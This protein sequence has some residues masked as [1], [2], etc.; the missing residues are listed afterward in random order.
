[1]K[2]PRRVGGRDNTDKTTHKPRRRKRQSGRKAGVQGKGHTA[3]GRL[4]EVEG[5]R[6]AVR[7]QAQAGD[8]AAC[9]GCQGY[10]RGGGGWGIK[11]C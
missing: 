8:K 10:S 11:S 1:M 5:K 3:C 4:V 6:G 2:G 7:Q 9:Q